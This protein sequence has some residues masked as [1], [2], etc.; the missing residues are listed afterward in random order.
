MVAYGR[1]S[2]LLRQGDKNP[3]G[4]GNYIFGV[5]LRIDNALYSI[6]F[7][8]HA[9]TAEPIEIP[10]G[11]MTRVSRRYRVLYLG[12]QIPRGEGSFW[13]CPGH[14]KAL[15]IFAAAVAAALDA[16]R[17]IQSPITSCSRRGHSV[18]AAFAANG[19]GREW[20]DGSALQRGRSVIY[21]IALFLTAGCIGD[22]LS[23][24]LL[25]PQVRR[26][27]VCRWWAWPAGR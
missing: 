25:R 23:I 24:L 1:G 21:D 7:G 16:K 22:N 26:R 15:T 19:I 5:F 11:M 17:I 27:K 20:D 2:V 10:F 18:A 14:S 4:R 13:G 3:R 12:Y 8:T 9:K 6:A